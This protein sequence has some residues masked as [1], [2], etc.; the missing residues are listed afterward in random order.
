MPKMK[1]RK[2]AAKRLKITGSGK[3]IRRKSGTKHLLSHESRK[4]KRSRQI[5]QEVPKADIKKV[6]AMLPYGGL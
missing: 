6:K 4:L 5:D 3:V 1:T 2:A